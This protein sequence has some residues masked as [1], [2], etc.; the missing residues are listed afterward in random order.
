MTELSSEM[1]DYLETIAALVSANGEARVTDIAARLSVRKPSV[2]QA[3]H[4]LAEKGLLRYKPYRT[5]ALTPAGRQ[6]AERVQRRHDVLKLFL[7]DVLLLDDAV[8]EE[9]ACRLEHAVD[10]EALDRLTQFVEFVRRCSQ[11]GDEWEAFHAHVRHTTP[12]PPRGMDC[13]QARAD[14]DGSQQMDG[15]SARPPAAPDTIRENETM[16][17]AEVKVGQEARIV[18]VGETGH[19][20]RRML[21]MGAVKGTLVVVVKKAPLGDPIEVKL[22]G[23]SL[24]L[25]KKEAAAIVVEPVDDNG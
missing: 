4:A 16:N 1:E 15:A 3:L 8:A 20:R 25:R 12:A 7:A 5:P 22:K 10:K 13:G 21:D 19:I 18:R 9:N 14:R 24:T 11:I 6:V 23:Y 2:T 17:L